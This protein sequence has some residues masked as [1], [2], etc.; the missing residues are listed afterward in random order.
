M[1]G[2][3]PLETTRP[4]DPTGAQARARSLTGFTLIEL[5]VAV[6]LFLVVVT[7]ASSTFIESLK[8]QRAAVELM[9]VNDNVSST[10]E[11]MVREIRTGTSF[12]APGGE[13]LEFTNAAGHK[14]EYSFNHTDE[15]VEK[16]IDGAA[17]ERLTA[18][19]VTVRRFKIIGSGL[20]A[21]DGHQARITISIEIGGKSKNL[22]DITTKLQ[23]T[24][25]SRVI[26]G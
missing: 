10:L 19:N 25:S 21:D 16:S 24:V 23:T 4:K 17:R 22:Q 8:S 13:S 18:T 14:V 3:T 11:F 7:I 12:S 15:S 20:K 1:S 26:D 9:A 5:L 6:S 2:F